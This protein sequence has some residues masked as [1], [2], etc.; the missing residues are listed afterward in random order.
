MNKL[1]VI[2]VVLMITITGLCYKLMLENGETKIKG[3]LEDALD[4]K[5]LSV[6]TWTGII[7]SLGKY[8]SKDW[9]KEGNTKAKD[10]PDAKADLGRRKLSL[11]A[12][13]QKSW[14]HARKFA[15]KIV[16]PELKAITFIH[17]AE[18]LKDSAETTLLDGF[19]E[20]ALL[21]VSDMRVNEVPES[22]YVLYDLRRRV[23]NHALVDR[24]NDAWRKQTQQA[25]RLIEKRIEETAPSGEPLAESLRLR[26]QVR[27]H[28]LAAEIASYGNESQT[29]REKLKGAKAILSNITHDRHKSIAFHVLVEGMAKCVLADTNDD[30]FS[31]FYTTYFTKLVQILPKST[32][33]IERILGGIEASAII[34][35]AT[36]APSG[37]ATKLAGGFLDEA[38]SL[39]QSLRPEHENE[40]H[41][42]EPNVPP[43]VSFLLREVRTLKLALAELPSKDDV[44]DISFVSKIQDSVNGDIPTKESL[45]PE[46]LDLLLTQLAVARA[47]AK[48]GTQKD[49][50]N[51]LDKARKGAE[52][53]DNPHQKSAILR[54]I[55]EIA[56]GVDILT[57]T[58]SASAAPDKNLM[59]FA[60]EVRKDERLDASDRGW[61][62]AAYAIAQ[63]RLANK[64][65]GTAIGAIDRGLDGG[66]RMPSIIWK[67]LGE[68][69]NHAEFTESIKVAEQAGPARNFA[70][71]GVARELAKAQYLDCADK[72]LKNVTDDNLRTSGYVA[73]VLG[74]SVDRLALPKVRLLAVS[75]QVKFPSQ[76]N[77]D[78]MQ[79][80]PSGYFIMGTSER[81]I[82]QKPP[83]YVYL[84]T[85]YIDKYE[86]TVGQY[87]EFLR[88]NDKRDFRPHE[89]SDKNVSDKNFIRENRKK[90]V[91]TI[92][93]ENATRYCE[94][95]SKRLPTEA[96]WEKA[97]R[98][99]YFRL[100]GRDIFPWGHE[101]PDADAQKTGIERSHYNK[102]TNWTGYKD[103]KDVD[104]I[105]RS[106]EGA[107]NRGERKS[108]EKNPGNSPYEVYDMAGSV[109][110]WVEDWYSASSYIHSHPENP[111]GPPAGTWKVLRGGAWDDGKEK[112]EATYRLYKDPPYYYST[113]GFRCAR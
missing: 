73:I 72:Q 21:A 40:K 97:A 95:A 19:V 7:A 25:P 58:D 54:A 81:D 78:S 22:V 37:A 88:E 106:K 85:F 87:A 50:K 51:A 43:P 80:V 27:L 36:P 5:Q 44:E 112:L 111:K 18:K 62:D 92:T 30:G 82:D 41:K 26:E 103:L 60:D 67:W 113:I 64:A 12:A 77:E 55:V 33:P 108:G 42:S 47:Y 65:R 76:E 4:S 107:I 83:H 11:L 110:E 59:E 52:G 105:V 23:P 57:H 90:P 100:G 1:K 10:Y 79:L 53:L 98:G 66:L 102:Q 3:F 68:C 15:G 71:H 84:D 46:R 31:S 89:W 6:E 38:E 93:H 56:V 91:V 70:L 32:Y 34:L 96:E 20:Q 86:V 24:V 28:A 49:V 94:W 8:E 9:E 39:A 45:G 74:D 17:L 48:V 61:A 69:T 13:N 75:D 109:W 2:C 99:A 35:R 16:D 63:A 29:I 14:E 104:D 101:L